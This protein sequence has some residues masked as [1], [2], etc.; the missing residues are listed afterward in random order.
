MNKTVCDLLGNSSLSLVDFNAFARCSRIKHSIESGLGVILL[1]IFNIR[2]NNV[3]S[4]TVAVLCG[5]KAGRDRC[6]KDA[7]LS[8]NG[9][10]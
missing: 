8:W 1:Y 6:S 5:R 9:S 2:F 7:T 10:Q 3:G 4:L